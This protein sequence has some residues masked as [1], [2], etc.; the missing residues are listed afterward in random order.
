MEP[1]TPAALRQSCPAIA[2]RDST[3]V[4]LKAG[5]RALKGNRTYPDPPGTFPDRLQIQWQ[6]PGQYFITVAGAAPGF[7][8]LPNS[9]AV[10]A[11]T[12][13]CCNPTLAPVATQLAGTR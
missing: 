2:H 13:R 1:A 5:F 7:H 12:F 4:V 9:P 11:G 6:S 3:A 10:K 8:R